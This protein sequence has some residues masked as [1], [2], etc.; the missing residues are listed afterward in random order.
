M[1]FSRIGLKT[2]RSRNKE[3][4]RMRKCGVGLAETHQLQRRGTD[5]TCTQGSS[6]WKSSK[7]PN[8]T[9]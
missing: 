1:L 5:R 8:R 7:D 3:I 2:K 9:D 4:E 6:K